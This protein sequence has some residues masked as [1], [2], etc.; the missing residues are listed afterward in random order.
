MDCSNRSGQIV[1]AKKYIE[2]LEAA[3]EEKIFEHDQ[4]IQNL[5]KEHHLL[6]NEYE[7]KILDLEERLKN[8]NERMEKK[9]QEIIK[10][11]E[12]LSVKQE[13]I[14]SLEVRISGL[15]SEKTELSP[16]KGDFYSLS[17]KFT[18]L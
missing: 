17:K 13:Q 1:K 3:A 18:N 4:L 6:T 9:N 7:R 5:K 16:F 15:E 2:D 11:N 12:T 10:L 14:K 8:M